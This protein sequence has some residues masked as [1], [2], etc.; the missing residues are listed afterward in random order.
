MG[1]TL[2]AAL[3]ASLGQLVYYCSAFKVLVLASRVCDGNC[4]G[5]LMERF[6]ALKW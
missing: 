2:W 1:P 6:V 4:F 3:K 5:K